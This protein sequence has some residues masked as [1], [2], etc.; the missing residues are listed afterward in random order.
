M[1]NIFNKSENCIYQF[2]VHFVQNFSIIC[3]FK[4]LGIFRL[5]LTKTSIYFPSCHGPLP[6]MTVVGL[7]NIFFGTS[8]SSS[9]SKFVVPSFYIFLQ[10]KLVFF[11]GFLINFSTFAQGTWFL[12]LMHHRSLLNNSNLHTSAVTCG[13]LMN[14]FICKSSGALQS[15]H[16]IIR[17]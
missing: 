2:N 7:C 14:F 12:D 15:S 3:S 16:F 10:C 1:R 17:L 5:N 13:T 4:I 6:S 11:K 9:S 8:T